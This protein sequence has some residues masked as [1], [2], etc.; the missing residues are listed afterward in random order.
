M[1][2]LYCTG[3][4]PFP[5]F[6]VLIGPLMSVEINS[7]FSFARRFFWK[8][9]M[10]RTGNFFH[11]WFMIT[12]IITRNIM[13]PAILVIMVGTWW[14]HRDMPLQPLHVGALFIPVQAYFVYMNFAWTRGL[15]TPIVKNVYKTIREKLAGKSKKID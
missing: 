5:P 4:L 9:G 15:F 3:P 7:Y 2:L 12:W 1:M 6:R 14:G 8:R 11:F 13:Y 10:L